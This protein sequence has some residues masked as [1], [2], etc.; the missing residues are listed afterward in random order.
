MSHEEVAE[1]LGKPTPAAAQVAVHR[2]IVRL[3]KEMAR[4]H[5]LF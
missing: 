2:A 4:E 3:A 1:L 5:P